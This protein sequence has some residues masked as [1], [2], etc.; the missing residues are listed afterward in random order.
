MSNER[1]RGCPLCRTPV[2]DAQLGLRDFKWVAD[3]L[4]G[5]VAPMDIDSV[6]EKNGRILMMEM[7]PKGMAIPLGQRITLRA[8]ANLKTVDVWVVWEEEGGVW[9]E[10]GA[11]DRHGD[12]PFVERMRVTKL[13]NRVTD[14]FEAAM[15]EGS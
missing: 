10:V 9:V 13:K 15:E 4:P 8:F 12:I 14:W 1:L 5:R 2:A 7:K 11:M 6:L 3:A